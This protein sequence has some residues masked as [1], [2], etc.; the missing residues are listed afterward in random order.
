SNLPS[1]EVHALVSDDTAEL[2]EYCPWIDQVVRDPGPEAGV[3]GMRSLVKTL[4]SERY[5]AAIALHPEIR[6]GPVLWGARIPSRMAPTTNISL[7][8]YTHRLRQR[9]SRSVKPEFEY[10]QD[11]VLHFLKSRGIRPDHSVP[12]PYLWFPAEEVARLRRDFIRK[13]G[14]PDDHRLIFIHA[15]SGGSAHNLSLAQYI[16]LGTAISARQDC[17]LVLTAGPGE[18]ETAQAAVDALRAQSQPAVRYCSEK[19]LLNFARHLAFVDVFISGSTGPLHIAGA[20]N[21]PTA[22]FYSR[23][24]VSS[25][26]RWQ[27]LNEAGRRLGFSPPESAPETDM[28][29]INMDAAAREIVDRLL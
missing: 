16:R 15:G 9:R 25:S 24:R 11:L 17:T 19:G 8:F 2:A 29:S 3:E 4:R 22:G 27:T 21:R 26:L 14:I 13:Y 28:A 7:V 1:T 10:N 20:L 12:R 5:A 18:H 6:T 23:R